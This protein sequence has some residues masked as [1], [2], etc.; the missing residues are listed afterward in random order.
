[1]IDRLLGEISE[2][3]VY[4]SKGDLLSI[5]E[6]LSSLFEFESL[7]NISPSVV[8]KYFLVYQGKGFLSAEEEF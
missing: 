8:S 1:V 2:G 4:T 5:P 7:K 3:K 6:G